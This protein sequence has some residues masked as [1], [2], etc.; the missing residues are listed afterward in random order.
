MIWAD[1]VNQK[2]QENVMNCALYIENVKK[3]HQCDFQ[4]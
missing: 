4:Y 2:G 1:P 3:H